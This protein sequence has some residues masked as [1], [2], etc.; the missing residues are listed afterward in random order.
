MEKILE[1]PKVKS[2]TQKFVKNDENADPI[3]TFEIFPFSSVVDELFDFRC[4]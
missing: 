2:F 3:E 4:L 1:T